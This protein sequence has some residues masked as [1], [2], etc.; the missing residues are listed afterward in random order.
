[1]KWHCVGPIHVLISSLAVLL[2][3]VCAT[4]ETIDAD[5]VLIRLIDEVDVP[6][7]AIGSLADVHASE[8]TVVEEGQLLAQI[9]DTESELDLRRA[10]YELEIATHEAADDVAIRS[11][12]K[13]QAYSQAH[14]QRLRRA[15]EAQPR[16][17]SDSELEKAR[18]D[19]E[20]A[21][22]E[23]ERGKSELQKAKIRRNAKANELAIAQRNIDVRKIIAPMNGMVVKVLHQPGEWVEPGEQIFRIVRTDRLRAEG[24]VRASDVVKDLRGKLVSV[25]P[26]LDGK[27]V[28]TFS[29]KIVFVSPEIDPVNGQVRVAAEIEN[30]KGLLRPGLRAKMTITTE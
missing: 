23:M 19:S 28:Q 21:D 5:S 4:G 16:S 26:A 24:F 8:G 11:A 14:F 3:G 30:P 17:V 25:V 7:R 27:V 18:L 2:C 20:Q 29:G 6:A 1:M 15:D 13:T 9:D 12:M 22:F 10:Q